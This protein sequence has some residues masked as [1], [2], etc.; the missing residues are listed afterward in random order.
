LGEDVPVRVRA[1][2]LDEVLQPLLK[3][4]DGFTCRGQ[5]RID[6]QHLPVNPELDG[7]LQ[8][9]GIASIGEE[10]L[11]E[12]LEPLLVGPEIEAG[13]IEIP[14]QVRLVVHHEAPRRTSGVIELATMDG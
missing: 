10:G 14:A 11:D 7:N 8:L 6:E 4:A 13:V 3:G 2:P 1:A 5:K 9:N 12:A